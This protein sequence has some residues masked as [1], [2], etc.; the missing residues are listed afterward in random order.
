[1]KIALNIEWI[2]ARR[3]GAEKYAGIIARALGEAGHEVHLFARGV[4]VKELADGITVH[5]VAVRKW[6]GCGWFHA[7][8][9][10][11]ASERAL[12]KEDFDLV[13][14]F[15]KTW[16][17]DVYLA[18]AGAQP[19]VVEHSLK[20]F[21]CPWR[22]AFHRL[23]K[24]FSP[25]QWMFKLIEWKQ[26]R[27]NA[28][29]MH[30][31]APSHFVARQ[32]HEHYNLPRSRVSI[33]HNGI[34]PPCPTRGAEDA[35]ATFRAAQGFDDSHVALL[36]LARNYHLK[37]LEPLLRSFVVTSREHPQA[38]LVVCGGRHQAEFQKMAEKL[39]VAERVRF[40][41]FVDDVHQVFQG[42][43]AFV[44]PTFYDPCS[45]VVPEAMHYGLPV[46][47]TAQNGAAEMLTPGRE[48]FVVSE[49]WNL[50]EL[51]GALGQLCGDE[52][53]RK[54]MGAEALRRA[55]RVT[56]QA[57]LRE[58]TEVLEQF[59]RNERPKSPSRQAA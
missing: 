48:G 51:A 58:L 47:T 3:G 38:R 59:G 20:R 36:F 6:P 52:G 17:Q 39:G 4:D 55:E 19:A 26:F 46:V 18:V 9:F 1:M 30:V 10:A 33:V 37:G 2:G 13:I 35:R 11:S 7:Y 8:Q 50:S 23:G 14:G 57:R 54:R 31:I 24:M 34:L 42:C 27:G 16:Y 5:P 15:N 53:L 29:P 28:R 40:L 22:R 12:K 56:M 44:L 32:F 41:G 49:A 45:L 25:K 43:D 21:E